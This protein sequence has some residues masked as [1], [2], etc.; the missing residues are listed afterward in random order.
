M[1]KETLKKLQ[2]V[3]EYAFDVLREYPLDRT[4][5][6]VIAALGNASNRDRIE[7]LDYYKDEPAM[8]IYYHI[9]NSGTVEQLLETIG[10]LDYVN[11]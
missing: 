8:K 6:N 1:K 3:Q 5:A 10:F 9:A 11:R 7:L 4:A 2:E